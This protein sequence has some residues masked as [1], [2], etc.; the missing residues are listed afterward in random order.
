ME[1]FPRLWS[2]DRKL[3]W[4][5]SLYASFCRCQQTYL[6]FTVFFFNICIDM[7][8]HIF[9][10]VYVCMPV[11]TWNCILQLDVN[12][13][14]HTHTHIYIYMLLLRLV[15]STCQHWPLQIPPKKLGQE[16][17]RIQTWKYHRA[18]AKPDHW[19]M[20]YGMW[21]ERLWIDVLVNVDVLIGL[22]D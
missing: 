16:M 4:S 12:I 14:T 21:W 6:F 20:N 7:L 22:L 8:I 13:F 10:C 15:A 11:Y 5:K 3:R 19:T 2:G 17:G 1:P 18:S 9:E